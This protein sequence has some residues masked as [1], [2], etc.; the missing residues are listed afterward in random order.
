MRA[1]LRWAMTDLLPDDILAW[2]REQADLDERIARSA[3]DWGEHWRATSDGVY[4]SDE[5]QH[6]G[7]FA[8]GAWDH[9]ED[10]YAAHIANWDPGRA[11]AEVES[12]RL[13]LDV[14][15]SDLRDDET[16]ETARYLLR[17]LVL[18]YAGRPGFR[19]EWRPGG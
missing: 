15:E 6:P 19:E 18:P 11:L 10:Q 2:L 5:S 17:L 9:R 7:P 16:D 1:S 4:P 3:A 13:L 12:K 14:V 8:V